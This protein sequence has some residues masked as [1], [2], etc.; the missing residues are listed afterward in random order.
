MKR[1]RSLWSST[2]IWN[3]RLHRWGS[4]AAAAPILIVLATGILLQLKKNWSWVQPPTE[5]G[6][7]G[8]DTGEPKLDFDAILAAAASVPE[9]Q[10]RTWN[11]VDRL[12]VRPARGVAKVR[13]HSRWEVQVDTATGAVLASAY[14]RSDVIESIHDGSFFGDATKLWVFLPSGI[15]LFALWLTGMY[16]WALPHIARRKKKSRAAKGLPKH[17]SSPAAPS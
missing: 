4:I 14:R 12:D 17:P 1:R 16:L 10:I 11:D 2:N 15:I 9:A 8:F 6:A 5:R 7:A 13:A 3:R